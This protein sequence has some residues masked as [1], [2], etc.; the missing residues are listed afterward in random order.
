L[1]ETRKK[2]RQKLEEKNKKNRDG[3]KPYF[4]PA[5]EL[6]ESSYGK[7]EIRSWIGS[8]GENPSKN[9]MVRHTI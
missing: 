5:S 4:E 2:N 7:I 6:V 3:K 1:A 9:E 8:A